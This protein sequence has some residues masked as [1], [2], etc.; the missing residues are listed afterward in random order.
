MARR[1]SGVLARMGVPTG[2]GRILD[3][4]GASARSMPL[5]LLFQRQTDEGHGGSIVVG[6]IEDIE[7][8]DGMALGRGTLLESAPP[9]V[10]EQ[11]EQGVIGPSVDLDDIEYVMD[12]DE[13]I[14]M[15]RWR[16]AGATLVAIPAFADV[17]VTLEDRRDDD[18]L[19]DYVTASV[20][21]SG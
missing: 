3:P 12:V 2:D 6:S 10:V 4:A 7:F 5:P 19:L 9:D 20:R 11:L 1:W 15:T 18:D 14:V 8:R 21:S 17:S 13:N 16:V